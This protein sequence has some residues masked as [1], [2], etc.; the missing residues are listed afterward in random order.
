VS[1]RA[2]DAVVVGATGAVGSALTDALAGR[3]LRV[4][5]V[6][7]DAAALDALAGEVD[8]EVAPCVADIATNAATDA[9][10]SSL[11]GPVRIAVLAAGLPVTGSVERVDPDLLAAGAQVKMAGVVRLLHAVRDSM[12]RGSRFVAVAGTLGLEPGRDEA[13]PGGV[14]AGL[15][16]LMKQIALNHGRDG[17]T[18]HTLVPGPMDTPRLRRIAERIASERGRPADEVW[19]EYEAKVPIGRL[20]RVDE[21]VWAARM[22]LEPEADI[23]HGTVLHLDAGGL[24]SPH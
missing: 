13:G 16:N 12:V 8:G 15:V 4:V 5:A 6:A 3:G 21:L 10:R 19:A 22:L 2:E 1:G 14:N 9:I 20:P 11:R 23:L 7:R 24:R 17:I 18:V